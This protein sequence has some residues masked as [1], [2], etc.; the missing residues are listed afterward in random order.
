MF[1][2]IIVC[3][4]KCTLCYR[5]YP[6]PMCKTTGSI[7]MIYLQFIHGNIDLLLD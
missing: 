3:M 7:V 6:P 4:P 2:F 5:L 1:A